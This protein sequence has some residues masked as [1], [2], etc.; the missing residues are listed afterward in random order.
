MRLNV[1][2]GPMPSGNSLGLLIVTVE[3]S[4]RLYAMCQDKGKCTTGPASAIVG[5]GRKDALSLEVRRLVSCP[6]SGPPSKD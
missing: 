5:E 1:E 6:K 4:V 3:G 2:L